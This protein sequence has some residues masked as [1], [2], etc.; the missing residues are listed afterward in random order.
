MAGA[1]VVQR[2]VRAESRS[3]RS[4]RMLSSISCINQALRDLGVDAAPSV[5]APA[6]AD[7]TSSTKLL[8]RTAAPKR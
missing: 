5:P 6:I 8:R 2:D 3:A 7:C 1:E 4:L